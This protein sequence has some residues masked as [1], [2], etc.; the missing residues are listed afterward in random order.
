MQYLFVIFGM[1]LC[2]VVYAQQVPAIILQFQ[3]AN[4]PP[5]IP[6]PPIYSIEYVQQ[7]TGDYVA[8][9]YRKNN[10]KVQLKTVYHIEK[11]YIGIVTQWL[12]SS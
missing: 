7:K 9:C 8:H 12:E 10:K 11:S 1:L 4:A 3:R 2:S 6:E 5:A